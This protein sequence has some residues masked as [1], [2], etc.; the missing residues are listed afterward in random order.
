MDDNYIELINFSNLIYNNNK[1]VTMNE[2][3]DLL[4]LK[5]LQFCIFNSEEEKYYEFKPIFCSVNLG[6]EVNIFI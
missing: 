5:N 4:L 2:P 1:L 3:V 6:N